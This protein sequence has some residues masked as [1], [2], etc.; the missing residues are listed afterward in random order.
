VTLNAS[1]NG[2]P[3]NAPF[4]LATDA[5]GKLY[6]ADLNNYRIVVFTAGGVF[7][8]ALST[9]LG[10]QNYQPVGVCVSNTGIV[11]VGNRAFNN[12][13][14]AGNAEFFPANA[15]NNSTPTGFANGLKPS[16]GYCAFDM[17]GNFFVDAGNAGGGGEKIAYVARGHVNVNGQTLKDS[18]QGSAQYW[19]GMYS[20][21]NNPANDTL[22]VGASVGSS[23]T[24]KV[25]NWKIG[26]PPN[27]PLAFGAIGHYTLTSY[28]STTDALY[29]LAP[30]AGGAGGT[31]YVADYG[32][33]AILSAPAGG[34]AVASYNP[35]SGAVGVA[36]HP[37]GQ[38]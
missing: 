19:V 25:Y 12:G 16:E 14:T 29:Q 8:K 22:S 13:S 30:S 31:L 20:R 26:G 5:A 17:P 38:Y 21:I 11:G 2:A 32:D 37:R 34:G 27:G 28:P 9:A 36:T 18:N 24:E 15:A 1:Y 33:G 10:G 6:V 4:G 35:V 3:F 7:V 23:T